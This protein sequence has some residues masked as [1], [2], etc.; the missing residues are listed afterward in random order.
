MSNTNKIDQMLGVAIGPATLK[1][2]EE[3]VKA[4]ISKSDK[5]PF[6][7]ACANP[8]SLVVAQNDKPFM[9]ALNMASATVAD[10]AGVTMVSKFLNMNTGPRITGHD[11]FEM[12]MKYLN[13]IKG[14]VFF[15]GSSDH[16]LNEI[17]KQLEITYPDIVLAG[18]LSPPFRE[19]TTEENTDM[20][21]SINAAAPDVLWVGMTAPKQEKWIE[22]NR[23]ALNVSIIGAIGAVFDFF[24]GTYPR[25]PKLATKLGIEWLFRLIKEPKRMWKRNFVST[26]LFLYYCFIQH[27][28]LRKHKK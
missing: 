21:N 19:W 8:H 4:K 16:V 22:E 3:K 9:D 28:I 13:K 11:F 12:T 25:A 18:T 20:I 5:N 7:F 14:R 24:A 23:H 10:G 2:L 27:V 15:F 26:P 1:Q 6:V 17:R